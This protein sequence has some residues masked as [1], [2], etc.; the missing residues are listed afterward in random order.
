MRD[1]G[2]PGMDRQE[3][4]LWEESAAVRVQG[5]A[6]GDWGAMDVRG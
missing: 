1:G 4:G 3:R 6:D 2:C 5:R